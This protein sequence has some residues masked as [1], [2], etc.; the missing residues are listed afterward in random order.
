MLGRKNR[1]K[2]A[3][4]LSRETASL[5][6]WKVSETTPPLAH[7]RVSGCA[8]RLSPHLGTDLHATGVL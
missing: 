3:H 6:T 4:N 7:G 5:I 8:F 1:E 2:E